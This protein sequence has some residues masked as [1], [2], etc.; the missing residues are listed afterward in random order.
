MDWC[1]AKNYKDANHP[2]KVVLKHAHEITVKSGAEVILSGEGSDPD[3]NELSYNWFFY[4]EVG[5]L[6]ASAL[7]LNNPLNKEV[8]FTAPPVDAPKTMHFILEVTDNGTPSLTRYQRVIVNV[9]PK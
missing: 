8:K 5:S 6:N 2:P 1:V 7:T 4:K 9:V 3:N